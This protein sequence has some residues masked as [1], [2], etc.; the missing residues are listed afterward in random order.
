MEKA[1]KTATDAFYARA[2]DI[3]ESLEVHVTVFT[4]ACDASDAAKVALQRI[5]SHVTTLSMDANAELCEAVM[6]LV[7]DTSR[8]YLLLAQ[9]PLRD[10]MLSLFTLAD[11]HLNGAGDDAYKKF[12]QVAAFV[13]AL[14]DPVEALQATMQPLAPQLGG[15]LG[16]L[17]IPV[18]VSIVRSHYRPWQAISS[19]LA[20]TSCRRTVCALPRAASMWKVMRRLLRWR[21]RRS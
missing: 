12:P 14:D 21:H 19:K 8:L 20:L 15:L 18:A 13:G 11:H 17:A 1:N 7:V 3:R 10:M 2:A 5:A 16:S 9:T 6:S 4:E